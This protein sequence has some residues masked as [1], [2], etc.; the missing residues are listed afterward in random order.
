MCVAI[1]NMPRPAIA[2]I[3]LGQRVLIIRFG[4]LSSQ[5]LQ[6]GHDPAGPTQRDPG[7]ELE[8]SGQFVN[9]A[10]NSHRLALANK[11][12]LQELISQPIPNRLDPLS[13]GWRMT[14]PFQ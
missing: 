13:D 10:R 11:G 5:T 14:T 6:P 3:R 1:D 4:R 2:E 7:R 8:K 9:L 12:Q